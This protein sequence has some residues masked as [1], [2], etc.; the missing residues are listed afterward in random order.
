VMHTPTSKLGPWRMSINVLHAGKPLARHFSTC[1]EACCA[2]DL[3]RL[4]LYGPLAS[5]LN[6][7]AATYTQQR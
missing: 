5:H 6:L 3:A 2:A 7:P 4:A 1:L